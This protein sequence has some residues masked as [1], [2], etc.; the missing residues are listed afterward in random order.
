[1]C[2]QCFMEI[3]VNCRTNGPS[4]QRAF[5]LKG[6]HTLKGGGGGVQFEILKKCAPPPPTPNLKTWISHWKSYFV[7]LKINLTL[8]II[9]KYCKTKILTHQLGFVGPCDRKH[10]YLFCLIVIVKVNRPLT[11]RNPS[12]SDNRFIVIKTMLTNQLISRHKIK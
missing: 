7:F 11:V 3:F 1:M 9:Q 8:G 4:D 5:G 6:G 10:T 2:Y 12:N